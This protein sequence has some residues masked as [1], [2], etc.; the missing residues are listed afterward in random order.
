M[1]IRSFQKGV[2][3]DIRIEKM[4]PVRS[5]PAAFLRENLHPVPKYEKYRLKNRYDLYY[6]RKSGKIAAA[7]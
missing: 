1:F 3:T 7:F 5:R 2:I 4:R 6:N